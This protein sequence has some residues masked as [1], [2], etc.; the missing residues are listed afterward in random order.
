[1]AILRRSASA[2][3]C[4]GLIGRFVGMVEAQDAHPEYEVKAAYLLNFSRY[5][6]WPPSVLP[7]ADSSADV[8]ICVLGR[9]PFGTMLER[10]VAERRVLGHRV[11]VRRPGNPAQARQCH[12]AFISGDQRSEVDPWLVSLRGSPVLTVGEG[13]AFARAGGAIAFVRAGQTVRFEANLDALRL[14]GVQLSS[15]VLALATRRY[16]EVDR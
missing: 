2:L 15:R 5:T 16:G 4:L 6:A 8:V 9:D 1:M 7:T 14:A 3:A 10:T 13:S 11:E 12:V